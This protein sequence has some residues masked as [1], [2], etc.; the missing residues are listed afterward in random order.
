MSIPLYIYSLY[1]YFFVG[2]SIF[3]SFLHFYVVISIFPSFVRFSLFC[4]HSSVFLFLFI[5]LFVHLSHSPLVSS[6][7]HLL[8]LCLSACQSLFVCLFVRLCLSVTVCPSLFV[9][10]CLSVS[11]CPSLFVRLCL[12]IWS[13]FISFCLFSV[14]LPILPSIFLTSGQSCGNEKKN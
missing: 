4:F 1:L 5:F 3:F 14:W 2:L 11:V 9:R 12:S 6:R 13:S 8:S 7:F 10:L